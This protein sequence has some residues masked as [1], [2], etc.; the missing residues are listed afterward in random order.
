MPYVT[1]RGPGELFPGFGEH[2]LQTKPC[3]VS[4]APLSL[5]DRDGRS[6]QSSVLW[7]TPGRGALSFGNAAAE[8][9]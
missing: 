1:P 2:R 8:G 6:V 4:A 7:A 3:T 5:D 9:V